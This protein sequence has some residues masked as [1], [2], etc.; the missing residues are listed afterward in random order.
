[1]T[2]LAIGQ[3][4]VI[5]SVLQVGRISAAFFPGF[6]LMAPKTAGGG[7]VLIQRS[8]L[9][10]ATLGRLRAPFGFAIGD[11]E[12]DVPSLRRPLERFCDDR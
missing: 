4:Q 12:R 6:G 8:T 7:G 11:G 5:A 3:M 1:M 10:R 9:A 2:E